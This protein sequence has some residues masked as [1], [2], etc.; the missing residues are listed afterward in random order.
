L[1]VCALLRFCIKRE[2]D[3]KIPAAPVADAAGEPIKVGTTALKPTRCAGFL[4]ALYSFALVSAAAAASAGADGPAQTSAGCSGFDQAKYPQASIS[5]G[6]VQAVLYLPDAKNGYYRA[7]RFDWS[8]V[9]PCLSYKGHTYFGIWFSH[10][11]PMVADA[12]A[13]PVEEFRSNDGA[14]DYG[15]AKS[16]G[17][18]VKPGV[19]VLRKVDDSAYQFM[20]AYPLVD[21]GKW[22]VH[23]RR[24]EVS[25]RQQLQSPIGIAYDYT[26]TVKL[27]PHASVLILQHRLKNTGTK[28][29]DTEVYDHD[30]FM[31]DGAPTGPGMV[32][33]FPFEPKAEHTLGPA[34]TIHGNEIVYQDELQ[35]RQSAYSFLNGYSSS[36]SD[37]DIIVEDKRTGVGVEQTADASI[38]RLNFWSIRTTICPEAYIHL[39]IAPGQTARLNIRYRFYAK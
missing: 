14:L 38:A 18:F 33:R 28:T 29:I 10:Y 39:V 4:L 2:G 22:T 12:V 9:I 15:Q 20:Y 11:D 37:Y 36:P 27:D 26:K 6:P 24:S 21:G 13:G 17:L 31:L 5:N 19:G 35:P 23:A 7:S 25:F 32:V 1:D 16:G 34:A 3:T 8:G 30:F